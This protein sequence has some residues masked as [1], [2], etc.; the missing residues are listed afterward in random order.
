[1]QLNKQGSQALRTRWRLRDEDVKDMPIFGLAKQEWLKTFLELP[2]GIPGYDT[3]RRVFS[4]IDSHHFLHC[5]VEWVQGICPTL[6]G[7]TVAIDGKALRRALNEGDSIPY[8]VNA[9]A[10]EY[11]LVLGQ[12]K[13]DD[14]SNEI[15]AIP[16]LLRLLNIKGCLVT[17]DA[18]GTQ[19]EIAQL[20]VDNEADY[21]LALKGNQG[22][23]HED[24]ALLFDDL[25]ESNFSAFEH[26]HAKTIEK[27]HGRIET[28]Q[29][30]TISDP[31]II[32]HLRNSDKWPNLT[33]VVMVQAE[34]TLLCGDTKTQDKPDKRFYLCSRND[35]ALLCLN[36][37]RKHWQVENALHWS[38]DLAF[39]EDESRL[40]KG[41]SAQNF[42]ILRHI[43]LNL[44]QQDTSLKVGI[45]NKRLRAGWDR[46][47]L[48]HVLSGLFC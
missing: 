20:I 44:L 39:R 8:I 34:R 33:S 3:F 32:K 35:N 11:G 41:N 18:M 7:E 26:E 9:W 14:K 43:A 23:L 48:L 37:T 6:E 46:N 27:G 17:I 10:S 25:E 2:G 21:L 47:Y 4:A 24:V 12:V 45:H 15:T 31:E 38:L 22:N 36:N 42:S 30:W 40:R 19:T 13:V 5:F 16:E 29:A 1:M 28:R